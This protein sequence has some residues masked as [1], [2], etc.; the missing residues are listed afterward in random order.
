MQRPNLLTVEHIFC[1]N[2]HT[3]QRDLG[4]VSTWSVGSFPSSWCIDTTCSMEIAWSHTT[5]QKGLGN[6]LGCVALGM[7]RAKLNYHGMAGS[8]E[9]VRSEQLTRQSRGWSC[10]SWS[11]SRT[12][13]RKTDP[14][15]LRVGGCLNFVMNIGISACRILWHVH[16]PA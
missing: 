10:A 5:S 14:F 11:S 8:I 13:Q 9:G 6:F 15:L 7:Q 12:F 2:I 4:T 1:V 16:V 3:P